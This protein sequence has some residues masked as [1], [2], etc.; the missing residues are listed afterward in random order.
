MEGL[1]AILD[2]STITGR[3]AR[4]SL[5]TTGSAGDA[6]SLAFSDKRMWGRYREDSRGDFDG[7]GATLAD[8]GVE[9]STT[10]SR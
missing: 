2:P 6:M 7:A 3:V 4:I 10:D 9:N 8:A 1:S 5:L